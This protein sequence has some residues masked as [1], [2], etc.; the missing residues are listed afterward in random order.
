MNCPNHTE[1]AERVAVVEVKCKSNE[2]FTQDVHDDHEATKKNVSKNKSDIA[3]IRMWVII[4]SGIGSYMGN[5]T[6]SVLKL[7]SETQFIKQSFFY[8][9]VVW[10][11]FL[12]D[13][14][15]GD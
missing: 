14:Y 11:A 9:K 3:N 1:I 12:P 13:S 6:P 5:I 2:V 8:C 7:L 15:A 4:C 10:K